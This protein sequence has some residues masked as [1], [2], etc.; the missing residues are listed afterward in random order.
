MRRRSREVLELR[1][2]LVSNADKLER[3]QVDGYAASVGLDMGKFK[4]CMD[5]H[6][7][8]AAVNRDIAEAGALNINGTPGFVIGR[9]TPDGVDGT[10]LLGAHPYPAFET[11]I[12][13]Y[14]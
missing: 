11:R 4:G 9:T 7:H 2:L 8:K 1:G 12:R 10:I 5:G 13:E 6:T 3:G 14:Q